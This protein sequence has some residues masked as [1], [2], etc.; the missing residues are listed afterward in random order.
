MKRQ[1]TDVS[2]LRTFREAKYQTKPLEGATVYG[3]ITCHIRSKA[4]A[5][6]FKAGQERL[7]EFARDVVERY[8]REFTNFGLHIKAKA[9]K[10]KRRRK[11]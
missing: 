10:P 5:L 4:A 2:K 9:T 1:P 8:V 6:A 3:C 11:P 7:N